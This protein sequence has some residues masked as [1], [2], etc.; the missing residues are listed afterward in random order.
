MAFQTGS[1]SEDIRIRERSSLL[2]SAAL[3]EVLTELFDLL[4]Q[5]APSWYTQK[6]HDKAL[7]ALQ[8]LRESEP[9]K[10]GQPVSRDRS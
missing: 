1:E 9:S 7:A 2:A 5:Y 8:M 3:A 10:R 6:H 4:E